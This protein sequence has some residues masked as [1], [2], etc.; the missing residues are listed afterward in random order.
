MSPH[1]FGVLKENAFYE[2]NQLKEKDKLLVI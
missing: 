2:Y 1:P